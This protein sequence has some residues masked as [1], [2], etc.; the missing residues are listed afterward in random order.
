MGIGGC[1]LLPLVFLKVRTTD[2][3]HFPYVAFNEISSLENTRD[4]IDSGKKNKCIF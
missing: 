3:D 1:I 2:F 4:D